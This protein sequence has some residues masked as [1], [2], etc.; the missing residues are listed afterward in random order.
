MIT[1]AI[2]QNI[3]NTSLRNQRKIDALREELN[4]ENFLRTDIVLPKIREDQIQNSGYASGLKVVINKLGA[5]KLLIPNDLH[6]HME[7]KGLLIQFDDELHFNRYRRITLE[8]VFYEDHIG[9]NKMPYKSYC[10]INEKECIKAGLSKGVW[11]NQESFK[12]FGSSEEPGDLSLERN[13]SSG[14]KLRAWRDLL[15]DV[16]GEILGFKVLRISTYDK[17]MINGKI[18]ALGELLNSSNQKNFSIVAK[19][20]IRRIINIKGT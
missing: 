15:Q 8:S 9:F 11:E 12:I 1:L 6:Y 3:D 17:I 5:K 4:R 16:S 14:W 7:Y 13:G 10:R 20:L 18:H 19:S 2:F